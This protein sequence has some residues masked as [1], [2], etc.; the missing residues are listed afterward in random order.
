MSNALHI[1]VDA[2]RKNKFGCRSQHNKECIILLKYNMAY[3]RVPYSG[4]NPY[5]HKALGM[6]CLIFSFL[7][8]VMWTISLSVFIWQ[9]Y[10][11]SLFDFTE[12][13]CQLVILLYETVHKQNSNG[14]KNAMLEFG[15]TNYKIN[16]LSYVI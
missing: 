4:H 16:L 13:A 9:L 10:C 3:S 6:Y 14:F 2:T 5:I 11:R 15:I 8:N 7:S 12:F 1:I